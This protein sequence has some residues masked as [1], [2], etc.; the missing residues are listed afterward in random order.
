M[1]QALICLC[2][3]IGVIL[4]GDD[5]FFDVLLFAGYMIVNNTE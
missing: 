4:L 1:L 2:I 5:I 3:F